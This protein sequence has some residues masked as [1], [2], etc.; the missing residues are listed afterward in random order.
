MISVD[1]LNFSDI[2]LGL[3]DDVSEA[4]KARKAK[5]T[6][7]SKAKLS[8]IN[9]TLMIFNNYFSKENPLIKNPTYYS[10]AYVN[11]SGDF[12]K[13]TI[14]MVPEFAQT[15]EEKAQSKKLKM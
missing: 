11:K 9:D 10:T 12:A 5:L 14:D 6:P 7:E 4:E 1:T 3:F 8:E 13:E 2:R 15:P